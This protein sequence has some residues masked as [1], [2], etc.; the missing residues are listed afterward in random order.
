MLH[1][2]KFWS[3]NYGSGDG[4]GTLVRVPWT[5]LCDNL[6][7][8]QV[9][10]SWVIPWSWTLKLKQFWG[11]NIHKGTSSQH[12]PGELKMKICEVR[13]RVQ[14]TVAPLIKVWAM[15]CYQFQ[16]TFLLWDNNLLMNPW[17]D[18]EKNVTVSA[19]CCWLQYGTLCEQPRG[20]NFNHFSLSPYFVLK[21]IPLIA[22]QLWNIQIPY[23]VILWK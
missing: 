14:F 23:T 12:H 18:V 16:M 19:Q 7:M 4:P 15:D 5:S 21:W 13:W 9:T 17:F 20:L 8:C 3:N 2:C 22:R 11:G 6:A 1:P 10:R